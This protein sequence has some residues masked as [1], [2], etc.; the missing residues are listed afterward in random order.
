MANIVSKLNNLLPLYKH[1]TF[2]F[3]AYLKTHAYTY[4]HPHQYAHAHFTY[5]GQT[6][7]P[8]SFD[9]PPL[10]FFMLVYVAAAGVPDRD[11]TILC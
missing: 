6:R 7:N 9:L 11:A 1:G 4:T 10:L 2:V 5:S 3:L 8:S